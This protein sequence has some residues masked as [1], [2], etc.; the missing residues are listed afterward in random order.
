MIGIVELGDREIA[1]RYP[2]D[3]L[4]DAQQLQ[5]RKLGNLLMRW[6]SGDGFEVCTI[7][8]GTSRVGLA[9]NNVDN[10]HGGVLEPYFAAVLGDVPI[11]EAEEYWAEL[12]ID[13]CPDEPY[14]E[15]LF[16]LTQTQGL[17]E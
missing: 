16:S 4:T 1:I 3:K 7:E 9:W 8:D 6:F 5:L 2:D 13:E 12:R 11:E 14:Q 10:D 17:Q 15:P